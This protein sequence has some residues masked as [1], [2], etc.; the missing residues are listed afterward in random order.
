MGSNR[1]DPHVMFSKS[2]LVVGAKGM[3]LLAQLR[4]EVVENFSSWKPIL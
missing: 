3:V 4:T 2:F 1:S